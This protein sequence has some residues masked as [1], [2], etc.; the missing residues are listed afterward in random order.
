[1]TAETEV[2]SWS[3]HRNNIDRGRNTLKSHNLKPRLRGGWALSAI[4]LTMII[5]FAVKLF[6]P[7]AAVPVGSL[8]EEDRARSSRGVARCPLRH[9]SGR[10]S[11]RL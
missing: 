4:R 1:M 5:G 9:Q 6:V 10:S 3:I 8:V 11:N 7:D 2:N